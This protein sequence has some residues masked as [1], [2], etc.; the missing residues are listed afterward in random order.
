M[1]NRRENLSKL[2]LIVIA[3]ITVARLSLVSGQIFDRLFTNNDYSSYN[4]DS[5]QGEP[6]RMNQV[7]R[8][9]MSVNV[10]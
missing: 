2:I 9:M 10:P 5:P 6:N 8:R 7:M 3:V 4:N 1:K